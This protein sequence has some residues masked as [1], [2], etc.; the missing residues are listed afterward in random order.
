[1]RE[2]YLSVWYWYITSVFYLFKILTDLFWFRGQTE[3]LRPL[4]KTFFQP[5]EIRDRNSLGHTNLDSCVNTGLEVVRKPQNIRPPVRFAHSGELESKL[6]TPHTPDLP[7]LPSFVWFIDL[8]LVHK[9]QF[10]MKSYFHQN[11]SGDTSG[12]NA[13]CSQSNPYQKNEIFS[14]WNGQNKFSFPLCFWYQSFEFLYSF[15]F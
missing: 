2:G 13:P 15:F 12:S 7:S 14:F 9:T 4:A 5:S 6:I 8:S 10:C 3:G 11:K 1:M